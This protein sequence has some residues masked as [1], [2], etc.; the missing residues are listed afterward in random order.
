MST[1][2]NQEAIAEAL[3]KGGYHLYLGDH[4][5]VDE[6]EITRGLGRLTPTLRR[7][8]ARRG[9]DLVDGRGTARVVRELY[10]LAKGALEIR[11]ARADDCERLYAWRNHETVRRHALDPAPLALEA[12]RD[13]FALALGNPDRHL[14]V[15]ELLSERGGSPVGVVRYDIDRTKRE[16]E[17]SIYLAP[18]E[19]GE[20]LG[21]RLL[22]RGETWLREREPDVTSIRALIKPQNEASVKLFTRSH[23]EAQHVTYSKFIRGRHNESQPGESNRGR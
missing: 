15:G 16:A 21:G 22:E 12:H 3:A 23:F 14:L 2:V 9:G 18:E 6:D 13:W 19:M 17:V 7:L 8:F 11:E 4:A 10:T 5:S 1:A 20:G